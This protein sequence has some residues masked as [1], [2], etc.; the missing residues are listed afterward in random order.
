[1]KRILFLTTAAL[2][3]T[4]AAYAQ[5]LAFPEAMGH[6]RFAKGGRGGAVIFVTNLND[7]GAGSLR[8][9]VQATGPRTCVFTVSGEIQIDS[10]ISCASPHLTIAGQTS[11]GGVQVTNRNGPNLDGTMRLAPGC[12][13]AIIRHFRFRPGPPPSTSSNVSAIQIESNRVIVDHASISWSNDQALNLLGNGG[14]SAGGAGLTGGDITIQN[15]LVYEPLRAANHQQQEHAFGTFL[16]AA[17]EDISIINTAFASMQRRAP[18]MEPTSAEWVNSLVHNVQNPWGELYCKHASAAYNIAGSLATRGPSTLANTGRPFDVF[19][20]SGLG[21]CSIFLGG[22]G[23]PATLGFNGVLDPKDTAAA[24]PVGFGFSMPASA[25]LPPLSAYGVIL[26]HAGALPRDTADVRIV[27]EIRTCAGSIKSPAQITWP[28]LTGP[29]APADTDSDGMPNTWESAN[30]TNPNAADNNGDLDADGFTN[31][32]EY[33]NALAADR[34]AA[35]PV[36]PAPATLPCGTANTIASPTINSFTVSSAAVTP[37]QPFTIAWN[38]TGASSCK[39]AGPAGFNGSIPCSGSVVASYPLTEEY[40]IDLIATQ[41]NYSEIASRLLHVNATATVPAPDITLT[42][43]DTTPDFGQLVTLT[44]AEVAGTRKL[45]SAI[46]TANSPDAFWTG[47]KSPTGAQRF[48]A[49]TSGVYSVTCSG[50]GGSDT[51]SVTLTVAGSPPPPPP[52]VP[53]ISVSAPATVIEGTNAI[54]SECSSPN[55]TYTITLTRTGDLSTA[56]SVLYSVVEGPAPEAATFDVCPAFLADIPVDFAIGE[57][58]KT[59]S[60]RIARDAQVEVTENFSVV[61]SSPI[62]AT[63]GTSVANIAIIDDDAPPPVAPPAP[64][65]PSVF[66]IGAAVEVTRGDQVRANPGGSKRGAQ[67][68][69]ARGTIVG[70]PVSQDGWRWWSVDFEAGPD[71]WIRETVL[72]VN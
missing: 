48:E 64:A 52:P 22:N 43:S 21:N 37:G 67:L 49:K 12:D 24:S 23:W 55:T 56:S 40:E 15:T 7:A 61:L 25:V 32:E 1:M 35:M 10:R 17:V 20:N 65:T 8:N 11:P 72:K 62:G 46:C 57:S 50:P 26:T 6:G 13:D 70:G 28:V 38:A 63:L 4:S 2:A 68:P 71:G 34:V 66:E 29:A 44:W 51:A 69:P 5:Q 42:A 18:L 47:F 45:R 39:A 14:T 31:L 60:R 58:V 27:N 59:I 54:G 16:S 41:G 53:V 19:D 36:V 9:C 33:L 3:M 30:G